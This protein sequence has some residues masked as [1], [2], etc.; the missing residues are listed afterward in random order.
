[1]FVFKKRKKNEI[2]EKLKIRTDALNLKIKK[3]EKENNRELTQ[4]ATSDKILF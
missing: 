3:K 1:M 4:T 2:M